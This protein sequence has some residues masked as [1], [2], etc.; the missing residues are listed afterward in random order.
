M[1]G[2]PIFVS[3]P[4]PGLRARAARIALTCAA[5]VLI[6]IAA[7]AAGILSIRRE[8][9]VDEI[10]HVKAAYNLDQGKRL[11]ADFW[12]GHHP[13]I[14]LL[15]RPLIEP[16]NPRASYA[17]ARALMLAVFCVSLALA[18]LCAWWLSGRPAAGALAAG[19]LSL[20]STF[21]E[22]GLEIR[23]D[24]LL[25]ALGLGALALELRVADRLRRACGQ[26]LLLSLAFLCTNKAALPCAAFGCLWLLGAWRER[27]AWLL[28]APAAVFAAPLMAALVWLAANG[29]LEAFLRYNVLNQFEVVARVAGADTSFGP[30]RFLRQEG[31]RNLLFSA[32]A[33]FGLGMGT[34]R[35]LR[36]RDPRLG[37]ATWIAAIAFGSLWVLPHPFPYQHVAV[38]PFLAVLAAA[39]CAHVAG[40]LRIR[41]PLAL[42]A[43]VVLLLAGAAFTSTP[44]LARQMRRSHAAQIAQVERI[45]RITAPDEPVFDLV[46]LYFRP[47]AYPIYLM[48]GAHFSR[49]RRGGF[50]AIADTLSRSAPAVIGFNYRTSWL[51]GDDKEF[52]LSHYVHYDG[53]LFVPGRWLGSLAPGAEQDFEVLRSRP[54]VFRGSGTLQ[55]DG[56]DFTRG[57][58]EAG[59]H[60]LSTPT[61][62]EAGLLIQEMREPR[63]EK[64]GPI[65]SLYSP[66]D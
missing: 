9:Q 10:E 5:V 50:P 8:L 65:F 15:L 46:G 23:P 34:L 27:R 36:A 60:R 6:G 64:P 11:Y 1:P 4:A 63:P 51:Y 33:L 66:F 14:Y 55:V 45:S 22:R 37:A 17:R 12:Q 38:L 31:A 41:S 57:M 43:A 7:G 47:D 24:G 28:L 40:A 29:S 48:T 39:V 35:S 21:V 18:G 53:N 56:A 13:G 42:G 44:R 16:E 58:L 25:A 19:L 61:G 52:I 62:I 30:W 54:F 59:T 49:Y 26:A 3:H 2:D 32:A 20:H